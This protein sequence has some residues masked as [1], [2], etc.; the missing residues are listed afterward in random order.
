MPHA[1]ALDPAVVAAIDDL[2]LAARLVVEGLRAGPHRSPLHGF[3][4]E[5]SQHRPYRPGDDFRHLDWK[6]LARTDRLY[7]RQFRETTNLSTALVLDAS[8]SM[9][10]PD[11]G[12]SKF[13]YGVVIAAALAYLLIDRGDRAGLMSS[14]GERVTY[15][16]TRG[17]PSHLRA[18]L[19]QLQRLTPGGG[20]DLPRMIARAAE[21]LTRP[22]LMFVLSD[23]YD[24]EEETQRELRRAR[25]RGHDVSAIQL[26]SPAELSF[27]YRGTTEFEDLETA[28]RRLVDP[29]KTA[30]A[31]RQAIA[32]FL[33]GWQTSARR[34]GIDYVRLVTDQPPASFL[35]AYLLQRASRATGHAAG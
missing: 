29:R 33:D 8:G 23:F 9:A 22:G 6:L 1:S 11:S 21:L 25:M 15:L 10:F 17:G 16:P 30:A 3:S 31:Y 18:M 4:T 12:I 26:I 32:G 24:A 19:A 2:E 28:A 13:R 5:F 34:D 7:S 14:T 27:E 35:R 20:V